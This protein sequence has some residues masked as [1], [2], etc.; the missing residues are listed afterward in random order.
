MVGS[1]VAALVFWGS[2]RLSDRYT[3]TETLD[4]EYVLPVG[5]TFSQDPPATIEA[6]VTASG[7]DLLRESLRRG[8]RRIVIDSVDI[9][10]N[11]DGVIELRRELSE[12]FGGGDLRVDAVINPRIVV[13]T[14]AIATKAVPLV[15]RSSIGYAIGFSAAGEPVLDVDSVFVTG[16]RSLVRD[17]E[18]WRTDSLTLRNL[19]DSTTVKVAVARDRQGAFEIEP[20]A[21]LVTVGVQEYTERSLDVAVEVLGYDGPDSVSVF[22]PV[23]RVTSA[24]GL[25]DYERLT[26]GGYRIAVEYD[27]SRTDL[28]RELPVVVLETPSF[29]VTTTVEPRKVEAFLIRRARATSVDDDGD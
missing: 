2:I 6:N 16:P 29:A 12:A 10:R 9:R 17:L 21:T 1:V 27:A 8:N 28:V 5:S 15:L 25:D 24:V 18:V 20:E 19:R 23:V 22:P 26:A 3:H 14:E 13:R 7:W 4:L 11:P